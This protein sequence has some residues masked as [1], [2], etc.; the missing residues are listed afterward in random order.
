MFSINSS[1]FAL[2][3]SLIGRGFLLRRVRSISIKLDILIWLE[4]SG[5]SRDWFVDGNK[6]SG[7]GIEVGTDRRAVDLNDVPSEK[8]QILRVKG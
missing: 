1:S 8:N 6:G 2:S 3:E 4:G 5:R 7:V